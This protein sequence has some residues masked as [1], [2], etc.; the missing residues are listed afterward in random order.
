[1]E[2]QDETWASS[3]CNATGADTSNI[4]IPI[5]ANFN[6]TVPEIGAALDINFGMALWLALAMHTI[7]VEIYLHLTPREHERLRQV[8]YEKQLEAGF[9]NPG[10][11]GLVPQR[12]GDANPWFPAEKQSTEAYLPVK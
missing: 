1:M 7:G 12:I 4:R 5:V 9:K 8:S 3:G 10:S 2:G 6:G 11:A